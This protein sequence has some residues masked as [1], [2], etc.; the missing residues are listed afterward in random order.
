MLGAY[1]N[2]AMRKGKSSYHF[3]NIVSNYCLCCK[4]PTNP[5]IHR[6]LK[7]CLYNKLWS[8]NT[9]LGRIYSFCGNKL[10]FNLLIILCLCLSERLC[11]K[12]VRENKTSD[13][14]L[15][16]SYMCACVYITHIHIHMHACTHTHRIKEKQ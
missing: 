3:P 6:K 7:P 15:W 4:E 1:F 16:P 12:S 13:I 5:L 2:I 14:F 9:F 10:W 11:L 8:I